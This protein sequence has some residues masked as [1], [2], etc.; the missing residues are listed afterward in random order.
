MCI[1][2]E[3]SKCLKL[4]AF[5]EFVCK[6]SMSLSTNNVSENRAVKII[7]CF[8]NEFESSFM[9]NGFWTLTDRLYTLP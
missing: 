5:Q 9:W 7:G 2:G 6:C 8:L 3:L 4:F 1:G